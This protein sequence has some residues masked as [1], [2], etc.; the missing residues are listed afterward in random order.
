VL[1]VMLPG[2]DGFEI[3]AAIREMDPAIPILFLTAKN[4]TEDLVKGFA[5]GGNDYIR[6]P[7][8]M[9][10]LMLRIENLLKLT[11]RSHKAETLSDEIPLGRSYL[12]YPNKLELSYNHQA[13]QLSHREC[14]IVKELYRHVNNT[15]DRKALLKNIWG[16]DSF[17]NSR[18]L[19][20]YINKLRAHFKKDPA[21]QIITLKGVGYKFIV[22]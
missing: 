11:D 18:N 20:V 14:E 8:S 17:Y 10:E 7:F 3:A 4:Q 15:T 5:S 9:E 6:K 1:D 21:I 22:T 19:D 13:I 2:K 16:D 12:F